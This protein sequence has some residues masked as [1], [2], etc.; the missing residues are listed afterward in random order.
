MHTATEP[1][2]N[3]ANRSQGEDP[4]ASRQAMFSHKSA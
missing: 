3:L 2:R 4:A 1:A